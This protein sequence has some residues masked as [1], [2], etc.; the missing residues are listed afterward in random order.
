M[1]ILKPLN[2]KIGKKSYR[3]KVGMKIPEEVLN[4]W[5]E[6]KQIDALKKS[7]IIGD[8][9]PEKKDDSKNKNFNNQNEVLL[10]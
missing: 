10:K 4:F 6:S 5:K 7:E 1:K 8:K 3:L 9:L 2:V